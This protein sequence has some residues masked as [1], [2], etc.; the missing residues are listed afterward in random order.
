M[1]A[2]I[3]HWPFRFQKAGCMGMRGGRCSWP[4]GKVV[5]GSSV[6]HSMMHTRGN[7]RDYD[8]WAENGNEGK[9]LL[10]HYKNI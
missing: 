6:L 9:A 4:R 3:Y 2:L 5:G 8:R 10:K 7:R 1:C